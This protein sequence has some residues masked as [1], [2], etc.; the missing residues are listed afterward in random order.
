MFAKL[1][2]FAS[3]II[4]A[5][6]TPVLGQCDTSKAECCSSVGKASDP[7]IAKELGLLGVVLQDVNVPVGVGCSPIT[8]IGAG[9]AGCDASPVCCSD[10]SHGAVAIGCVPLDLSL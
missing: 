3:V 7:A 2:S 8:V 10:T 4:L 6:A 1:A 5:V 9:S